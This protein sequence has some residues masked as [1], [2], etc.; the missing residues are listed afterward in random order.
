VYICV[1]GVV[2]VCVYGV[3]VCMMRVWCGVVCGMCVFVCV[4]C[5]VCE[6]VCICSVCG[7]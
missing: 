5:D 4:L 7:M 1:C 3:Y 2:C 6:C